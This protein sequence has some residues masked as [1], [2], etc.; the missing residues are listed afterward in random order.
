MYLGI[1]TAA[2]PKQNITLMQDGMSWTGHT[3]YTYQHVPMGLHVIPMQ[4]VLASQTDWHPSLVLFCRVRIP[5][6]PR[7]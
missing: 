4:V 6:P 1:V 3:S 7:L 2:R 5:G